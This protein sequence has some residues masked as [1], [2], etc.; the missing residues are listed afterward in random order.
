LQFI[1]LLKN[2]NGQFIVKVI[3]NHCESYFNCFRKLYT[4]STCI[5]IADAKYL[6][7]ALNMKS[8]SNLMF[9]VS[10]TGLSVYRG[11]NL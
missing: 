8:S 7:T 4:L 10:G 3:L 5:T 11:Q 1:L 2:D 6:K 9:E